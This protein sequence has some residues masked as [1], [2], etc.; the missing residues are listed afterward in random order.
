MLLEISPNPDSV[1]LA[2][3]KVIRSTPLKKSCPSLWQQCLDHEAD[4]NFQ[5]DKDHSRTA[6]HRAVIV[7]DEVIVEGLLK[8][9]S[10]DADARGSYGSAL[11]LASA[12]SH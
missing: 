10:I 12:P 11:Q 7:E 6:L 2:F 9:P 5:N 3:L 4:I 8:N 1:K